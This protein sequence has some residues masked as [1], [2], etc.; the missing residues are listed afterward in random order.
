ME[1][2]L[3]LFNLL[4]TSGILDILGGGGKEGGCDR[5]LIL[6]AKFTPERKKHKDLM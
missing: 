2:G 6:L 5:G 4:A 1:N 3:E